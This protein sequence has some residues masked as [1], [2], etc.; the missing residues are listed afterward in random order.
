MTYFF[1][2]DMNIISVFSYFLSLLLYASYYIGGNKLFVFV[3]YD[4]QHF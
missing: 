3:L 1:K 2:E 4:E